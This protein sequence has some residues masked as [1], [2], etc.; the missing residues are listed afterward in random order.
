M[1]RR[2][3]QT[4]PLRAEVNAGLGKWAHGACVPSHM[5]QTKETFDSPLTVPHSGYSIDSRLPSGQF[6]RVSDSVVH[7]WTSIPL[8]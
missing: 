3:G 1:R 4:S 7:H 5:L 8:L 6:S 2:A